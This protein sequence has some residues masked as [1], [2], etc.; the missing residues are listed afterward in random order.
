[1]VGQPQVNR[2]NLKWERE[3]IPIKMLKKPLSCKESL[4]MEFAEILFGE[5]QVPSS[6]FN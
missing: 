1:M 3:R 6:K 2:C 4:Y 5:N